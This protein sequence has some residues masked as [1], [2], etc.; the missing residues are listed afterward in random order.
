MTEEEF[1]AKIQRSKEQYERGEYWT[2]DD[3]DKFLE[4]L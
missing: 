2:I 4:E 3:V 1:E